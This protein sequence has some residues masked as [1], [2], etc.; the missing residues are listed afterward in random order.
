MKSEISQFFPW[1]ASGSNKL[2]QLPAIEANQYYKFLT[3]PALAGQ[4]SVLT[5]YLSKTSE[6]FYYFPGQR[7]VR[8]M[9]SFAYDSP[10]I[11]MENQ[12]M[13][14]QA[15]MFNGAMDRFEWK[16]VGK[17]ELLVPYNSFAMY[18]V[19]AKVSD[20]VQ[21]TQIN[22]EKRRY[23]L[24]RVWVVEAKVKGGVRHL[25]P[26]RTFYLDEDSWSISVAEDYDEQGKLWKLRESFAIPVFELG[27]CDNTQ[28]VQYD[29]QSGRYL[30]D[31]GA[32]G[33]G[34][35]D[36]RWY[37]TPDAPNLKASFYTSD[38]LSAS[39]ER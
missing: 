7:R 29:M 10:L 22:P 32:A 3:P 25:A 30:L 2:S 16:L 34:G 1:G 13:I 37:T 28:M 27:S 38:G 24:H 31:F 6:A 14:D 11:G 12:Y 21:P 18:D 8:R 20:V 9:P 17:K 23:E 5:Q 36:F 4:A 33:T 39:S 35:A 15:F 26:K 19:K